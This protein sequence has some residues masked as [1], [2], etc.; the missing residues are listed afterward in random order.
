MEHR[1]SDRGQR[2]IGIGVNVIAFIVII[3]G[4]ALIFGRLQ[5]QHVSFRAD[6]SAIE[7]CLEAEEDH[8]EEADNKERTERVA[9]YLR[10]SLKLTE[11]EIQ[12]SKVSTGQ[13]WIISRMKGEI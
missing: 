6:I 1:I 4:A 11:I 12:M 7:T 10:L 5:E 8:R 9:E 3:W 13:D 2:I